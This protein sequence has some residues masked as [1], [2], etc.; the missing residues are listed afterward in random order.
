MKK[1][2]SMLAVAFLVSSS[3]PALAVDSPDQEKSEHDSQSAKQYA[4]GQMK[5]EGE[6]AKQYAPGQMKDEGESARDIA[7]G[8]TKDTD[9]DKAKAAESAKMGKDAGNKSGDKAKMSESDT[10]KTDQK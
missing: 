7:P 10:N 2:A 1:T 8:H 4:P 6:S 9:A 3:F 5:D